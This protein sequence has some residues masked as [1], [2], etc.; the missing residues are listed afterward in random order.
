MIFPETNAVGPSNR[1][2]RK[3]RLTATSPHSPQLPTSRT[4]VNPCSSM[5]R[6]LATARRTRLARF[7]CT[8]WVEKPATMSPGTG[9]I[10]QRWVWQSNSPGSTYIS[11]RSIT[12][13]SSGTSRSAPTPVILPPATTMRTSSS[14]APSAGS[15]STPAW[16]TVTSAAAGDAASRAATKTS[17]H[18][19]LGFMMCLLP[20]CRSGP[21]GRGV[22]P[23]GRSRA[24]SCPPGGGSSGRHGRP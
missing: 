21:R 15:T 17:G 14:V 12:A 19:A 6:A 2:R 10:S 16:I 4:V 8:R 1:P 7:S 24:R 22:Q 9:I 3:A 13:A 18:I 11:S 20:S 5:S 23:A